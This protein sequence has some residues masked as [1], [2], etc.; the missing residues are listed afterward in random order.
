[1]A[2][3]SSIAAAI[4]ELK[5]EIG[6]V[7]DESEVHY[8]GSVK[9]P[10]FFDDDYYIRRDISITDIVLQDGETADAKWVTYSEFLNMQGTGEL[11]PY[12][13]KFLAPMKSE[14]ET[15]LKKILPPTKP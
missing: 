10:P 2:G 12:V 1:M 6:I 15:A 3:E 5:E 13:M 14:F 8:I 7:A 9:T 4:R 11:A